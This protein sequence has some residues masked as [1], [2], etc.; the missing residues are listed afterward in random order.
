MYLRQ[1]AVI[2]AE[3]H[4]RVRLHGFVERYRADHRGCT[5]NHAEI[6]ALPRHMGSAVG[7]TR[8]AQYI[9]QAHAI[10]RRTPHT[11]GN[12]PRRAAGP[13]Q[14]ACAARS[15]TFEHRLRAHQR[16][17]FAQVFKRKRHL[18]VYQPLD[19][20]T[21]RGS[22]EIRREQV[23]AH[24]HAVVGRFCKVMLLC[25]NTRRERPIR[26]R[27]H[28]GKFFRHHCAVGYR[29][30]GICGR[31]GYFWRVLCESRAH[32]D[33]RANGTG[34]SHPCQKFPPGIIP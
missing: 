9:T 1:R 33:Y 27:L 28:A 18:F 20:Q 24:E 19:R 14:I 32:G 26:V 5:R 10:P 25:R 8:R 15:G 3:H 16:K 17:I 23:I 30:S 2:H 12:R 29:T 21:M 7:H 11:P 13:R 6:A 4:Q 22:V 31:R 34:R